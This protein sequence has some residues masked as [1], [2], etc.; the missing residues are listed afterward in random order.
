MPYYRYFFLL[1]AFLWAI[2][3]APVSLA[4]HKIVVLTSQASDSEKNQAVYQGL[5]SSF[6][7][8]YEEGTTTYSLS[9]GYDIELVN[10]VPGENPLV[11]YSNDSE[12][13]AIL[14][15]TS[16]DCALALDDSAAKDLLVITLTATSS[17]FADKDNIFRLAPSN[18]VQATAIYEH[19]KENKEIK[20]FGII[21][22]ASTYAMDLYSAFLSQYFL[23]I[24]NENQKPIFVGAFPINDFLNLSAVQTGDKAIIET[25]L[26]MLPQLNLDAVIFAGF[27]NS[28]EALT[29]KGSHAIAQEWYAGDALFPLA[30]GFSGL[31][32]FSLYQPEH[33][34]SQYGQYYYSFDAGTLLQEVMK[35]YVTQFAE[36]TPQRDKFLEIA[37]ETHIPV[38]FSKTGRKSF[39]EADHVGHFN[40]QRYDE[41]GKPSSP[42]EK[43][44]IVH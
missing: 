13:I 10:Y 27:K 37:K 35:T 40:I 23:D 43:V 1:T 11:A 15:R 5:L 4:A 14:C 24:I 21:Y 20:R 39:T 30:T 31:H 16:S 25:T 33:E 22:E 34:D 17:K 3:I 7:Q 2:G 26:Q 36:K 6:E 41:Q 18:A 28:F 9:N 29:K 42:E 44:V 19:L 38:E 12:V 32:V 8:T